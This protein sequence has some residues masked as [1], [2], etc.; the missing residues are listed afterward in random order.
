MGLD[1][2]FQDLLSFCGRENNF[3]PELGLK[4]SFSWF[5]CE[6]MRALLSFE[7][8]NP[9]GRKAALAIISN[10]TRPCLKYGVANVLGLSQWDVDKKLFQGPGARCQ[11]PAIDQSQ[12]ISYACVNTM[13][14]II[15]VRVNGINGNICFNGCDNRLLQPVF[16][17]YFF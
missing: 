4:M 3:N 13:E 11:Y 9:F 12:S 1:H 8:A 2:R 17:L 14:D 5:A 6:W 10:M 16:L 7:G 15:Q